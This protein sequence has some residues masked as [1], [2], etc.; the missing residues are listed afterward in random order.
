[1]A[2]IYTSFPQLAI[3]T[4]LY[5]TSL[6]GGELNLYQFPSIAT[7]R[8]TWVVDN[9]TDIAVNFR[10][11]A[12]GDEELLKIL[13][14][15]QKQVDGYKLGNTQVNPLERLTSLAEFEPLISTILIN[16]LRLTVG[17]RKTLDEEVKRTAELVEDD[18]RN[19][20]S[21]L[22]R[23]SISFSQDIGLSDPTV[24]ALY[25]IRAKKKIRS[26]TISDLKRIANINDT[27]K[28]VE[29]FIYGAQSTQKRPPNLLA[30]AKTNLEAGSKFIPGDIYQT[31][32]PVP[33][34]GSLQEMARTF[35]GSSQKWFELVTINGL[36]PPFI[37][38][39]GTKFD[40][41]SP[42][43]SNSVLISSSLAENIAPGI[44]IGIGSTA[45]VEESRIIEKVLLNDDDTMTLFLGGTPDVSR[46]KP[47]NLAFVRIYKPA[48]TRKNSFILIPST[49][50][51]SAG[52]SAKKTPSKDEIRR[53]DNA[54]IQFGVDVSRDSNTNDIIID[55]NGDFK[56]AYGVAAIEQAVR[57]TLRTE[58]GELT[59]HGK[60]G[61]NYE[62]GK[63]YMGKTQEAVLIGDLLI[64][65][66]ERDQRFESV[67]I[68]RI[69]G[70]Q[71]SASLQ[72][73]AKIKG[74]DSPIPLNF[75]T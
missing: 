67:K 27:I 4:Q 59:Y 74:L 16:T 53:L 33:F 46:F 8:W 23:E 68:A 12:N 24:E 58:K 69:A 18:F 13:D 2:N 17:E 70:N 48:T 39:S 63:T 72:L 28:I 49:E 73:L 47:K 15:F 41:I 55:S 19:M 40:L 1:M 52:G 42:A 11:T 29:S 64:S 36:Q 61:V 60:F 65:S 20:I 26:A 21:F 6:V 10:S 43:S 30:I 71:S 22:R 34:S 5:L 32:I 75:V 35:L 45:F 37:D 44:R 3:D 66:I 57:N 62:L 54:Y 50:S 9:F 51:T 38:E 56:L 7:G 25:G 14:D 31:Y